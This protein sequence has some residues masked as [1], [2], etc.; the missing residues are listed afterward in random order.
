MFKYR[1]VLTITILFYCFRGVVFDIIP[2]YT[3]TIK[4][5]SFIFDLS[6]IFLGISLLN[7]KKTKNFIVGY[8][9]FFIISTITYIINYTETSLATHLNGLR[10][11]LFFISALVVFDFV[12][13]TN[14]QNEILL[15]MRKLALFILI[16]QLPISFYQFTEYGASDYVGGSFGRGGS[17][18]L[19]FLVFY[20]VFYLAHS[21]KHAKKSY[22]IISYLPLL[23]PV[24]INE[25]KI[26]FILLPLFFIA[27]ISLYKRKSLKLSMLS[28]GVGVIIIFNLIYSETIQI[29]GNP[30]QSIFNE[31]FLTDYLLS[32][33]IYDSQN[34]SRFTKL[35]LSY[36]FLSKNIFNVLFGLGY[37]IGRGGTIIEVESSMSYI[38]FLI[39][40][41]R[42][43]LQFIFVQGGLMLVFLYLYYNFYYLIQIFQKKIKT[44]Y[45]L[46]LFY[47]FLF[48]L[49]WFY[50]DALRVSPG[51]MLFVSFII[52]YIIKKDKVDLQR[53]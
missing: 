18:I 2:S 1:N 26:S 46:V 3:P 40:G 49:N 32:N 35:V 28:I 30:F 11:F 27:I 48:A 10:E 47:S 24:F 52:V 33:N 42:V 43:L 37:G 38:S 9:I 41:S 39:E 7:K 36:E 13:S 8:I 15:W 6:F 34:I 25:T 21:F 44:D 20:L 12:F 50:N 45:S 53:N 22:P 4:S 5:I 29:V 14:K 17:G 23:A 16:S 31:K 51:Y 19:T